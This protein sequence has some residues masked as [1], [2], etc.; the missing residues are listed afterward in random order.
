MQYLVWFAARVLLFVYGF[1]HIPVKGKLCSVKDAPI[2]V[3][4]PHTTFIDG[5]LLGNLGTL[6]SAVGR[7]E[8]NQI[9]LIG[10]MYLE[11]SKLCFKF[12]FPPLYLFPKYLCL[13]ISQISQM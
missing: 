13:C 12:C 5:F 2:V 3:V 6:F 10:C 8:N 7:H 1:W 9:F 4:A 11:Y